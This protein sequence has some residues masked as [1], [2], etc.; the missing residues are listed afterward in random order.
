MQ[1]IS[2]LERSVTVHQGIEKMLVPFCKLYDKESASTIEAT[3]DHLIFFLQSI[4]HFI[5]QC[6]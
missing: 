5:S 3:F 2:D 1:A 4:K 6:F